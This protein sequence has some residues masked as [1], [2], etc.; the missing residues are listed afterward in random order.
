MY[1]FKFIIVLHLIFS[2]SI[3]L[4]HFSLI[5]HTV[6]KMCVSQILQAF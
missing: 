5:Y 2:K 6:L 3:T 1:Y 4:D